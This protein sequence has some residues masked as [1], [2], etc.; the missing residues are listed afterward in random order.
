MDTNEHKTD[1][2]A[3]KEQ[4]DK[5]DKNSINVAKMSIV[6]EYFKFMKIDQPEFSKL[7]IK[8]TGYQK[9]PIK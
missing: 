2:S 6:K 7:H 3:I 9:W 1:Y 5:K 8:F 4:N